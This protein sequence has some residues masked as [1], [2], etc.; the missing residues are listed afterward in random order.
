MPFETI[1]AIQSLLHPRVLMYPDQLDHISYCSEFR[2]HLPFFVLAQLHSFPREVWLQDH[3]MHCWCLQL[4]LYL[5]RR[6]FHQQ[7]MIRIHASPDM[8]FMVRGHQCSEFGTHKRQWAHNE[9]ADRGW[10]EFWPVISKWFTGSVRTPGLAIFG[11]W[12]HIFSTFLESCI[13]CHVLGSFELLSSSRY[14]KQCTHWFRPSI[15][16]HG[17]EIQKLILTVCS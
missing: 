6:S 5:Q 4:I 3:Q 7:I 9:A 13:H 11:I 8:V 2:C 12:E 16:D 1:I 10:C 14:E 17:W 15:T